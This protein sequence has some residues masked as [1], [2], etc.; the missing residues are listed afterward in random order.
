MTQHD[1]YN[2]LIVHIFLSVNT[3]LQ[4]AYCAIVLMCIDKNDEFQSHDDLL[5]LMEVSLNLL[6]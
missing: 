6:P 5:F 3:F 1:V 4:V 2:V